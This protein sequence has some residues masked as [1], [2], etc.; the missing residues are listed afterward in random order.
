[1]KI[2]LTNDGIKKLD[3]EFEFMFTSVELLKKT[4]HLLWEIVNAKY[5][6][7]DGSLKTISK[8][9]AILGGNISRLIKLNTSFLENTC[10][11][12]LEI[13]FIIGRCLS[14][15]WINLMYM[16]IESEER[17]KKNY[18]KNSLITEKELW[19][20]I[21]SNIKERDEEVLDIEKRMQESISR[22]FDA[23]DFEVDEISRSSKWKS[24]KSRAD[25]VAGKQFYNI[26]YGISSHAIHGNWQ[27]ILSN[28]LT[29][30]KK[31]FQLKLDWQKPKTPIVEAIAVFNLKF[32][33]LFAQKEMK[34]YPNTKSIIESSEK[35]LESCILF[36][37][38][39]EKWIVNNA[40]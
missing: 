10:N 23:S 11:N 35:L 3:S 36:S 27:D 21:I 15:T 4:I 20:I 14:E 16:L 9:E 29:K 26:Y 37:E 5:K 17:V 25:A 7:N 32:I 39:H 30:T 8:E 2:D 1:M 38:C 40:C 6:N 19:N 12:K 34:E 31:G 22:S 13:C 24:I 18:V 28:N 33:N